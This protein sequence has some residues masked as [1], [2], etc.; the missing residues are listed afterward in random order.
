[1]LKQLNISNIILVQSAEID[2]GAG[3]NVLSGETGSGK[4]AILGALGLILGDKTNIDILREGTEKGSVQAIFDIEGLSDL[5]EMLL[6]AGIEQSPGE[7][8]IIRREMTAQGKTRAFINNQAVQIG[9]LRKIA[10]FLIRQVSQHAH[11]QLFSSDHHRDLLDIYGDL[12][13]LVSKFSKDW[14]LENT[15]RRD[16][17]ALEKNE[18]E[19]TREIEHLREDLE[20]LSEAH[21]KEGEEE[22]LFAEYTLL[23][24]SDE[25]KFT[26][27]NILQSLE[28]E[29]LGI[30]TL[31]N[32]TRPFLDQLI[33]M[34]PAMSST[35]ESFQ[36]LCLELKEIAYTLQNYSNHIE[37]NPARLDQVNTRLSLINK[38]K[39]RYGSSVEEVLA[40]REQMEK[41]LHV[42]ENTDVRI[43]ELKQELQKIE[44]ENNALCHEMT[45]ARR[46]L[47][48]AF[49]KLITRQLH[50]LNMPKAEF[51][52]KISPQKRSR[53][54]D[55]LVE[56]YIAPNPGER[57]LCVKDGASGGE[58]SRL[59]LSIQTL[60][61]GKE[62]I[63]TLIFDEVDSNIGGATAAEV[64]KKL[65]EI[66][67]KHQILCITHFPQVAKQANHHYQISKQ[68]IKG[69][70]LTQII[71]LD[72]H[73]K[74]QEL[75]R[76][77]GEPVSV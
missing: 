48:Q 29:K 64:G 37:H 74:Q 36:T 11:H 50:S 32:R 38:L 73:S 33:K 16:I 28:G 34:D 39:R 19:R 25:L 57:L 4:S 77:L 47:A 40:Q 58:L 41:R 43:A 51:E 59:L 60:L 13:A 21:L 20:E 54:G 14:D 24:N 72:E 17:E 67:A 76:M 7:D 5:I 23:S 61:A 15:L 53:K 35:A 44:K 49:S 65:K 31:L 10:P 71:C 42:L 18:V 55:D 3:F 62:Q 75:S 46:T 69:R 27:Q 9:F 66:G 70:T 30:L 45:T 52:I 8:L 22:E 6:E 2:F 68:E 1:M 63:P 56:F 26:V 12:H